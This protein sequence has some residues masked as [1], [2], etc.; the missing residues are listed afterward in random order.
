MPEITYEFKGKGD[1]G[2]LYIPQLV[3][4]V[5]KNKGF[6]YFNGKPVSGD[7][8]SAFNTRYGSRPFMVTFVRE[9]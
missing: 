8:L 7:K 3:E 6:E 9:S 4:D 1:L 2:D 5:A